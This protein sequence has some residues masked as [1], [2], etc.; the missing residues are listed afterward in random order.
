MCVHT[1]LPGISSSPIMWLGGPAFSG[2]AGLSLWLGWSTRI[3]RTRSRGRA[4]TMARVNSRM[5]SGEN[6][7]LRCR[8]RRR[9]PAWP[10]RA[11]RLSSRRKILEPRPMAKE[12][13]LQMWEIYAEYSV[14]ALLS[15]DY[16][17]VLS[18]GS[19]YQMFSFEIRLQTLDFLPLFLQDWGHGCVPP[20]L[21]VHH[22]FLKFV[23]ITHLLFPFPRVTSRLLSAVGALCSRVTR[24]I[25]GQ[26]VVVLVVIL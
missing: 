25:S 20:S 17:Q 8:A 12:I 3:D 9:H 21:A 15:I 23:S 18:F 11:R 26:D 5:G 10:D 2:T 24:G 1:A 13:K 19:D 4:R 22:I 14:K 7:S 16:Y 6:R